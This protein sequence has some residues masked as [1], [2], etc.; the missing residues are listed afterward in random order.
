MISNLLKQHRMSMYRLSKNSGVPYTT[1]NDICNGRTKLKNCSAETVYRLAAELDIPMETLL[2]PYVEPRPSFELFKSHICHWLNRE[3]DIDFLLQVLQSNDIRSYFDKEWYAESFYLLAMV[4]YISR[5]NNVERIA[6]Y[7]DIRKLRLPVVLYPSSVV[8]LSAALESDK[9][10][11]DA[12][13]D[14]IPEFLQ[15]NIIENEVR[16]VI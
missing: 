9:P 13:A 3:G 12:L 4:D 16:N 10:K 7:D 5:L 2:A 8:A 15:F 6:E 1:L 14:A 11:E